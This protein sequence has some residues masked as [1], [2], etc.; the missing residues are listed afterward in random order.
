MDLVAAR[1]VEEKLLWCF[2]LYD[3]DNS[4]VIDRQE[5]GN[6]MISVYNMLEAVN[7]RPADDPHARA[8]AIFTKVYN[9]NNFEICFIQRSALKRSISTMMGSLTRKNSCKAV[10]AIR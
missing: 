3:T 4:G 8:E 10:K 9:N 5:L 2:K 1:T 7:A 6:I